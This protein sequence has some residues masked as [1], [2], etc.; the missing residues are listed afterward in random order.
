MQKRIEA[1]RP[2]LPGPT[3]G[4]AAWDDVRVLLAVL[5][6]GS[7]TPAPRALGPGQAAVSRRIAAGLTRFRLST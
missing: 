3:L 5:R 4:R 7:F 1:R 6:H 2:P